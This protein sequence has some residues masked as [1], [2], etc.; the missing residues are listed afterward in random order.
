MSDPLFASSSNGS[1]AGP[2]IGSGSLKIHH[3]DIVKKFILTDT[4]GSGDGQVADITPAGR[5]GFYVNANCWFLTGAGVYAKPPAIAVSGTGLPFSRV[6]SATVIKRFSITNNTASNDALG[7][8]FWHQGQI[9][10]HGAIYGDLLNTETSL[11]TETDAIIA[12]LT[13]PVTGA[14]TVTGAARIEQMRNTFDYRLASVV[15]VG[16]PFRY[17][18]AVTATSTPLTLSS[19]SAS[20]VLDNGLTMAGTVKLDSL[21]MGINYRTGAVIG[22]AISGPFDDA[23]TFS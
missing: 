12:A 23:V 13:L 21:R 20:M 5:Y 2:A 8:Q 18:G 7:T 22:V 16:V 14:L 15:G 10:Y 4:T 3:A 6:F 17:S 1:F 9:L 11:S 19:I